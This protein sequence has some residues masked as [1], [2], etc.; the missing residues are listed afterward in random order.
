MSIVC[1]YRISGSPFAL[2]KVEIS[3]SLCYKDKHVTSL[4]MSVPV[5]RHPHVYHAF[6]SYCADADTSHARTILDSVE[7]RGFTCC[8]AERDFLP[9][10]CTSDVV[11]DAIH[12][13]KNVIL[14]ISPASLQSEW[15][16]FEML[17]AVDDSHQ[18][19]SVCLVPVLLG[20]VKVDDL[21]PPLRPLTCIELM[22][23]FR[24]TNDIIQAIS[25][26]EDTWESLLPVGNLAHGFAWGYYYGYLKIILP[27]LDKTVREWRRV[28]NAEGRMSEK[29]FLFF[30]QSCRCRDSIAD[31]SPLIKH[32]GHLPIITKDRAG[33]IERQYKNTIYSVTDDN[34]EDYFFAGEYIGVIHTM[35]EMEQNATTGLQTREKYIQ[36]MRFYLTVKRILDTDPEC[37][38]KCKIVFYKD[39]NNSPDAMPRLICNEIKNQLR[40]ESSDDT[41]VCMTPFNSPFPSIST[42]DFA[43]YSINSSSSTNMVKSEPSIYREES[44]KTKSVERG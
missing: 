30:P 21:P 3:K 24:N 20:G 17:M 33:I 25:K 22:D 42:P 41:T 39:V 5:L 8:F 4:T 44:G 36:S 28:N 2:R 23:D 14:V 18:R 7:S 12:C 40:K 43:R 29:L 38:E 15:S 13:S 10:E 11:V 1:G 9:G 16:K 32:R 6:I 31:E 35:F 37:S 34:G 26:P 19:N 27:D